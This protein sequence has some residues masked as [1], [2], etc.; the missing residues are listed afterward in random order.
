MLDKKYLKQCLKKKRDMKYKNIGFYYLSDIT[1]SKPFKASKPN[2]EKMRL[3]QGFFGGLYRT[4][5]VVNTDGILVDGYMTYLTLIKK[6]TVFKRVK[7]IVVRRNFYGKSKKKS[8][9][10]K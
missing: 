3:K 6:Y 5:I 8:V 7:C 4:P 9:R 10:N 2:K 1:I